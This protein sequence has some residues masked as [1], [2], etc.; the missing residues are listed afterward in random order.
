M[1]FVAIPQ[2]VRS[3]WEA[4]WSKHRTEQ[5]GAIASVQDKMTKKQYTPKKNDEKEEKSIG[6]GDTPICERINREGSEE[7]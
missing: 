6:Y 3:I 4:E 7:F 5:K 2:W 1:Y